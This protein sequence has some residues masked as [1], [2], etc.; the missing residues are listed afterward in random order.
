MGV[1]GSELIDNPLDT[2]FSV[3][4][5]IMGGVFWL[6]PI[7]IVALALYIKTREVSVVSIWIMGSCLLV[8]AGVFTTYPEVGFVYFIFTVIG[9]VGTIV[10]IFFMRR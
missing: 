3:F 10:S 8:G 2:V 6:L 7:G 5:D 9:L 4:T 1:N